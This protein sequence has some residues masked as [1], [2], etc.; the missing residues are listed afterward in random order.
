[1]KARLVSGTAP[2]RST[3]II[4]YD[5]ADISSVHIPIYMYIYTYMHIPPSP[6]LSLSLVCSWSCFLSGRQ[7]DF[8]NSIIKKSSF[9]IYSEEER[10]YS[11]RVETSEK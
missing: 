3:H 8:L 7:N 6:F 10:L 9:S 2:V 5:S 4:L 11:D 1:M